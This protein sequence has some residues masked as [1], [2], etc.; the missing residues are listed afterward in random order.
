MGYSD[1]AIHPK[2][3]R[4]CWLVRYTRGDLVLDAL[5]AYTVRHILQHH[6][7]TVEP[8]PESRGSYTV[9]HPSRSAMSI[10]LLKEK[11]PSGVVIEEISP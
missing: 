1:P 3:T 5:S 11:L 9:S 7:F 6:G 8:M 10:V 2:I 4:Y